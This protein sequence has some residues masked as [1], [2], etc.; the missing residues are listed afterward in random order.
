[1]S[2]FPHQES[3]LEQRVEAQKQLE[4]REKCM[5]EVKREQEKKL[6]EMKQ[7]VAIMQPEHEK[8]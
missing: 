5:A 3:E 6:L 8:I 7:E 1:M 4:E 2:S